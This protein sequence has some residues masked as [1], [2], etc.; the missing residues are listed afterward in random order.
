MSLS[1]RIRPDVEAAPWVIEEIKKLEKENA[2][3][4][5]MLMQ[6]AKNAQWQDK[7]IYYVDGDV[8][9]HYKLVIYLPVPLDEVDK[10][11]ENALEKEI[12]SVIKNTI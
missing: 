8:A 6:A 3:M 2:A 10:S 7:H 4:K 1:D 5:S 9:Q 11:V 12:N